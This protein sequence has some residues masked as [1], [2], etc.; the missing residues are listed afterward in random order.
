VSSWIRVSKRRRCPICGRADWCLLTEDGTAAICPR[1]ESDRR[2]GDAGWLHRL[3]EDHAWLHRIADQPDWRPRK[4]HLSV[5][6]MA[7]P[8]PKT[9][10]QASQYY[11]A[12]VTGGMLKD[13]SARLGLSVASLKR[14]QVG[15]CQLQR[16]TTWPMRDANGRVVGINRRYGDGKKMIF[17]GHCA[18]LYIPADL[19]Q[20]LSRIEGTLLVT[21]GAT[22]A[23]AALDLGFWAVGRFSCSHGIELLVKLISRIKPA[24]LVLVGDADEPGR[25]G[26]ESLA[27]VLLAYVRQLK[28]VY[29][30][31][32][33]RDL[34]AWR[35][36][37]ATCEDLVRAVDAARLRRLAV[38]VRRG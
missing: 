34:R 9:A 21:E 13:L 18:G 23:V 4:P 20:D 19:P 7:M 12:A 28:V 15:W 16:C 17:R 22:D 38:E 31:Q 30:P 24:R 32:P 35:Q 1:V 29:P 2:A 25:R 11:Q 27:S 10:E 5:A 3:A 33:H 36:A 6:I 14:F 8:S 37:G 26:V